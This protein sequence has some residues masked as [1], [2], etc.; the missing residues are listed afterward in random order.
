VSI[1]VAAA[2]SS[3]CEVKTMRPPYFSVQTPRINRLSDP[4]RM[5]VATSRPNWNSV[6]PS[7]ALISIPMIEKMVQTA[8]QAVN[9]I[10]LNPRARVRS[11]S[12]TFTFSSI[13]CLRVAAQATPAHVYFRRR[14]EGRITHKF[15]AGDRAPLTQ[16]KWISLVRP[17]RTGIA[18]GH[19][20]E[21][22]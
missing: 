14:R 2:V 22:N 18:F 9:A 3:I 1:Q 4:V 5:G 12:G 20:S 17:N 15:T 6:S 10:V 7:S 11:L 13:V 19:F 8:K 16:I 21:R